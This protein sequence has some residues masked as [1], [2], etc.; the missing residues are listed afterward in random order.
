M[1]CCL[2]DYL[3]FAYIQLY[4]FRL[5]IFATDRTDT[6]MQLLWRTRR[7][8]GGTLSSTGYGLF[9]VLE[10]KFSASVEF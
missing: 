6:V 10:S 1:G 4:V 7:E 9:L 5:L 3:S 2:S 8:D